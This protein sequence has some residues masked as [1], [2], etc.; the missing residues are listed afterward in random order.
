VY[1]KRNYLGEEF[2]DGLSS[3]IKYDRFLKVIDI[4]GNLIGE[5]S[6]R[7]L[8]KNSIKENHTLV[9]FSVLKNPG[10]TDKFRKQIALF[11]LKNIEAFKNS[12]NELKPDWIKPEN[13]TFKIPARI[14]E[15]L[16]IKDKGGDFATNQSYQDASRSPSRHRTETSGSKSQSK[17]SYVIAFRIEKQEPWREALVE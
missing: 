16:G 17:L 8:I 9:S 11:L 6:F 2:M 14:L 5:Q 10:L 4:T 12:G 1:L 7:Q 3:C 13:L 15:T